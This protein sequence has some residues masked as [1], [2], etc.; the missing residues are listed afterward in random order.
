MKMKND[1]SVKEYST[2][3]MDV[4][5]QIRHLDEAFINQKVC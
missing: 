1:K 3:L 5:N 2:I 4:I